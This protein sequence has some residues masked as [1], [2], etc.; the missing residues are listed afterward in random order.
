V[1]S[2]LNKPDLLLVDNLERL[3]RIEEMDSFRRLLHRR[4]GILVLTAD[5][6]FADPTTPQ[7]RVYG[8]FEAFRATSGNEVKSNEV[9]RGKRY[10]IEHLKYWPGGV[11]PFGYRLQA[12][13]G[14]KKGRTCVVG[15]LLVPDTDE[16]PVAQKVFDVARSTGFGPN[17]ITR[18]VNDDP[19]VPDKFKPFTASAIRYIL[20]NEIYTGVL[21]WGR[22][23]YDIV[24]DVNVRQANSPE[25]WCR[26]P[27]FCEPAVTLEDFEAVR[28]LGRARAAAIAAARAAKA[29]GTLIMPVVP[30]LALVYAL[31]G[32]VRCGLCGRAMRPVSSQAYTLKSTGET[33]YYVRYVCPANVEGQVCDNSIRVPEPWLR[34]V[35]ADLIR[36]RLFG[37]A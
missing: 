22:N 28:A 16:F 12:V 34:Q 27:N 2:G 10:T 18:L 25:D 17:R 15:H 24:A 23:S 7:G 32:L 14:E 35:V 21:V 13:M 3:G 19:T 31:T 30:G 8:M 33:K 1:K 4:H 6:K 20:N 11:P 9:T 29:D 37:V 36:R 26:V 5:S